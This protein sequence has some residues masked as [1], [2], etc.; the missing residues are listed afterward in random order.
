MSRRRASFWD[1][2]FTGFHSLVG[3]RTG[4]ASGIK[5]TLGL[6]GGNCGPV[7]GTTLGPA[8][9]LT[10]GMKGIDARRIANSGIEGTAL[11]KVLGE[12]AIQPS[13]L[14]GGTHGPTPGTT[15][16]VLPRLG[17][18]AGSG[19]DDTTLGPLTDSTV[20]LEHGDTLRLM[21]TEGGPSSRGPLELRWPAAEA[22]HRSWRGDGD[23]GRR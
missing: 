8:E 3:G 11:G 4:G 10:A 15:A 14:W 18:I 6:I 1:F 5:E 12:C 23:A 16:G 9:V 2:P 13:S 20:G 7:N 19:P 21:V 22:G 17:P